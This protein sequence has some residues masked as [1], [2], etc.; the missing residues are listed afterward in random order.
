MHSSFIT[1]CGS[2]ARPWMRPISLANVTF[3]AW[4]VLHA[5]SSIS[6]VRIE[7]CTNSQGDS[8]LAP[9]RRRIARAHDG[10][11]MI[12]VMDRCALARNLKKTGRLAFSPDAA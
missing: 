12:V 2:T 1:S 6:A 9:Q 11:R 4:K 8:R 5:Y 10:Q 7:V 3:T